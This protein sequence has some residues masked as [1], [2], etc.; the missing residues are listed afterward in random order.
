ME[1]RKIPNSLGYTVDIGDIGVYFDKVENDYTTF[2]SLTNRGVLS[3]ILF[4]G[5]MEQFKKLWE[6]IK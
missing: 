6:E 2:I 3:G 5:K 1:I 4:S